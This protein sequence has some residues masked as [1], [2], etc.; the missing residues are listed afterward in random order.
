MVFKPGHKPHN[1]NKQQKLAQWRLGKAIR[2]RMDEIV[3][4]MFK[5][6]HDDDPAIRLG[7]IKVLLDRGVG[8]VADAVEFS[9]ELG[10][11]V[12]LTFE[13]HLP[14]THQKVIEIEQQFGTNGKALP[15]ATN[16]THK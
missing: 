12:R 16:G 4:E 9:G 14:I 11:P 3:H 1:N 8:K 6:L 15:Q 2:G 5:L 7:T 13:A 10:G